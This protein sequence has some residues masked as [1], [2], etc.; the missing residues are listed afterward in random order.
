MESLVAESEIGRDA[1][2]K[3]PRGFP[4]IGHLPYFWRDKLGFLLRCSA[5]GADV[6][7]LNIGSRT[8]L[9]NNADDI[10]HVLMSNQSNYEK[11]P[12][13]IS[14]PGRR[15]FGK[16]LLALSGAAHLRERR[17]LQPVFH[18][19]AI[20]Q[21]ASAMTS[22]TQEMLERWPADGEIDLAREMMTLSRR[23]IIGAMFGPGN[24]AERELLSET[25]E[26]RRR[27]IEKVFSATVPWAACWPARVQREYRKAALQLSVTIYALIKARRESDD[28]ENS[29]LSLLLRARY[30]DGGSLDD[31]QIHDEVLNLTLAGYETVGEALVWTWYL[32]A[33]HPHIEDRLLDEL[34]EVCGE[35]PSFTDVPKLRY[36]AMVFAESMRLYP[37]TWLFVR[38][39]VRD[40]QLPSGTRVLAGT[41]IY[42]S[43]YVVHRNPRYFPAAE[44]FNPE[45]FSELAKQARPKFAYFPFGGG[46][47]V[48]IGESF[49]MLEGVLLT[50]AIG[51]RF[52]LALAQNQAVVPEPGI[53]LKPRDGCRMR[54]LRRAA[55]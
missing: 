36:T 15:L 6:V 7:P 24:A 32:L 51:Q 47:R 11:S 41:K 2:L 54:V 14:G 39:A 49:A 46:P 3:V 27:Y 16:G 21:F 19:K 33:Q 55:N 42:L 45:R 17:A 37:P 9:L 52:K 35:A 40:D 28:Q 12:R 31:E 34:N 48:C 4:V 50:A 10:K 43:P 38:M 18:H 8:L 13:I 25:F 22:C 30:E 26:V 1:A 5:S 53:T 23:I 20:A 44:T 29:M